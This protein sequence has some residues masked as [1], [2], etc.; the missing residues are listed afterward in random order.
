MRKHR[1]MTYYELTF[2]GFVFV[3]VACF[4]LIAAFNSQN[5]VLFW[6]LGIV[7]GTMLVSAILGDLLLRRLQVQRSV[8]QY[9]VA[10]E[11]MEVHYRLVNQKILW[12]S[13]AIRITEARFLG[14]ISVVPEGYCLH[15]APRQ[16]T[17]VLTHLVPTHRGVIELREQRICCSFPFGFLNRAVHVRALRRIVVF[18]RIGMLNRELL[19]RSRTFASGGSTSTPRRGGS[20]EF[21]G[22][23]EYQS[24]DSIRSIHWRRSAH[25][26]QLMVREMTTDTPPTIVVALDL[27]H[28]ANVPN[29]P[30][31]AERA[32]ELAAAWICRGL[33]DHFSVGL[34]IC[35]Y[36]LPTPTLITAGRS[37]R[38]ILLEALATIDLAAIKPGQTMASPLP[39]DR[40]ARKAE[41]IV[42]TLSEKN[43]TP[44]MVPGGCEYT[45]LAIEDP[46]SQYWVY[47]P[48]QPGPSAAMA[49]ATESI[50]VSE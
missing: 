38:Q 6:A 12:P 42:I 15:L 34:Q 35:G 19:A 1:H 44:D 47:F 14:A 49:Q 41:Y 13:C 23:R 22:L 26:G 33:M 36:S 18:P 17:L 8:G 46:E 16:S 31:L 39:P 27:R 37:Q 48:A 11:P 10:G 32:I 2:T 20:D 25:T 28:W 50:G 29:G 4:V 7:L 30:E 5:N 24:G 21:F 43:A 3:G 40:A 9:A 45:L